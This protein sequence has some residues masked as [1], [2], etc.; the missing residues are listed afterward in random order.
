MFLLIYS[1]FQ[2]KI[3]RPILAVVDI[4]VLKVN[5]ESRG[6]VLKNVIQDVGPPDGTVIIQSM[7][8]DPTI[9]ATSVF[10]DDFVTKLSQE[11]ANIGEVILIR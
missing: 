8:V 5:E 2:L 7:F 4:C 10:D 1:C 3:N 11:F 6:N 9:E